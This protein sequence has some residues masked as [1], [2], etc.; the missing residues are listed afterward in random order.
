MSSFEAY[1]R[2]VR[3]FRAARRK[4]ALQE[5]LARITGQ[6]SE[7]LSYDEVRRRLRA[8]EGG[9]TQLREIPLDAIVGSVGR[10]T[11]FTRD[12]LPRRDSDQQRWVNVMEK[13]TGQVG[14]PPIEVYQ[15]GDVYFVLDGNHRVSVARQLGAKTIQAYVTQVRSKVKLTP[16]VRPDDLIL[17]AEEI[18]FLE[19]TRLDELR[20]ET[21][22]TVTSPGQYPLLLEHIAVHRYFMGIDEQRPI[23][24]E[25]AVCHWHDAVYQP[26]VQVIRER[27]ILRHFP[28]RTEADLYLWLS[29][30]RAELEDALGWHIP[31]EAAALD[32]KTRF[33]AELSN[34][35]ARLASRILDLV[36]PD[37]LESGPPPG[38]WRQEVAALREDRLFTHILVTVSDRDPDWVALQQAAVIARR[39]EGQIQG[40]HITAPRKKLAGEHVQGLMA[41]F[42][43]RCEAMGVHGHLAVESGTVAR[44]ICERSRWTDLIVSKLTYPPGDHPIAR[45]SSGFRTMIRRCPRPILIVPRA[46]GEL[47]HALLAYNGAPKAEEALFLAAYLGSRWGTQL[48]V[49]T[50]EHPETDVQA[51]QARARTYLE[52]YAIT[53][54]YLSHA[55]GKRSQILLDT[56]RREGCDFILMG[57]YRAS[58]MVEVVLGSEVD[59]VLRQTEIPLLIC[60]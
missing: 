38:A 25:E 59:E 35:F 8:L 36:T 43:R 56:A 53:A 12:F 31:A 2:A 50:I 33:S 7:L 3:D 55:A 42:E 49:L 37:A 1:Y 41:E 26:V 32:L 34:S 60:R 27:G 52:S 14:L 10:Y 39:E 51:V 48:T 6:S 30:H 4:A 13:A 9:K 46:P 29:Q 15:I 54:R 40:L 11:D 44:V 16:D 58:P 21:D 5:I 19:Q 28:G 57:G 47:S 23:P 18:E 24:Y 20:P 17:K 22:F 45:L